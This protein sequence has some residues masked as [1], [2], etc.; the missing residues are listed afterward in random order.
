MSQAPH[1]HLHGGASAWALLLPMMLCLILVAI[2]AH[3]TAKFAYGSPPPILI[4]I[5]HRAQ[6]S[7]L[8]TGPSRPKGSLRATTT[9]NL[10]R[11]GLRSAPGVSSS[12]F[13]STLGAAPLW[14]SICFL[15][16]EISTVV[17]PSLAALS[18]ATLAAN[19]LR[20]AYVA[21]R[22]VCS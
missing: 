6:A 1:G 13:I 9:R 21:L 3:A 22:R 7:W 10:R 17:V 8:D 5:Y 14:L 2:S 15:A 19:L 12:R 4:S 20:G 16:L 18:I 11:H